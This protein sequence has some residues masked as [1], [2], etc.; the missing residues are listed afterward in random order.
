MG[1]RKSSGETFDFENCAVI[2]A[3]PDDETLW[4]GG[5][6]LM[7]PET[8]WTVVTLCRKSDRD[9]AGRFARAIEEFRISDFG[10]RIFGKMGDL[11]DGPEQK[12]LAENEVKDTI[13]GLL[14]NRAVEHLSSG[15][16]ENAR[17]RSTVQLFD[18]SIVGAVRE[19]PLQFDLIITH[20][21][22]GEYTRHKR[23]EETAKAVC[24]LWKSGRLPARQ[25]WMFAYEDGG[26]KKLPE[27]IREADLS[28]KLSDDIWQKKCNIVTKIYGFGP[29]SFEAKA[30]GREEAFWCFGV[31]DEVEK[32]FGQD[33][34]INK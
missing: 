13:V 27:P 32:K 26:G 15:T 25:M 11:D 12:P 3:H 18:R 34:R 22:C 23:H 19:P 24:E 9:R 8:R 29:D 1:E 30:A 14:A 31:G 2:V 5:T 21:L 33:N 10:F 16:G 28:V 7:H 17:L 6:I 20:S 4:A